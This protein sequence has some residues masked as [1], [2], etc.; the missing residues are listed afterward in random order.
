M[1]SLVRITARLNSISE[2]DKHSETGMETFGKMLIQ[3]DE[4][5]RKEE[6]YDCFA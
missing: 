2:T 4:H 3:I 6:N 5:L 1:M